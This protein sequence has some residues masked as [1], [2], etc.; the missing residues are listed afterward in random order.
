MSNI[1]ELWS[2]TVNNKVIHIIFFLIGI[3][4]VPFILLFINNVEGNIADRDVQSI[5]TRNSIAT[6]Y[7]L[8]VQ[9]SIGIGSIDNRLLLFLHVG[10]HAFLSIS[11]FVDF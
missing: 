10:K 1:V 9:T 7:S 11:Y 6:H 3:D 2:N 4:R 5:S 8:G